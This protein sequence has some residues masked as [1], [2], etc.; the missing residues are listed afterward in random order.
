[1][2]VE[3]QSIKNNKLCETKPISEKPKMNA[4]LCGKKDYENKSG[5]LTMPKQSQTNPTYSE[6]VE[7]ISNPAPL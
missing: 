2:K 5:L 4:T 7:P 6:L 3:N 1:V